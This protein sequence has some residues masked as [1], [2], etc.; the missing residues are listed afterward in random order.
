MKRLKGAER[1][2]YMK[3]ILARVR[4]EEGEK[5]LAELLRSFTRVGLNVPCTRRK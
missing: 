2:N 3:N 4:T 5:S 1:D